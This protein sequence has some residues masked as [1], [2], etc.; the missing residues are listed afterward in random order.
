[1]ASLSNLQSL[2]SRILGATY[3]YNNDAQTAALNYAR[4]YIL[5]NYY[6]DE[7]C[8]ETDLTL[9]SGKATI[10]SDYLRK[11]K[12]YNSSDDTIYDR[13]NVNDFDKDIDHSWTIKDDSGTR[14][15]WIYPTDATSLAL[16]YIKLPTDM[17]SGTD[18][19]GFNAYWDNAH[20]LCA[21]W[22]LLSN[23]RQ[24]EAANKLQLMNE[25]IQSCLRQQAEDTEDYPEI[26]TLYSE[27]LMF[28]E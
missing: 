5:L 12:L 17:A 2:L 15:I 27:K 4:K 20:C 18:D 14:K 13:K 23:D 16:R 1:M 11:V 19:S 6:V 8:V 25:E 28:D 26:T 10:P 7:F 21:A 24:P 3:I 9:S 22:W